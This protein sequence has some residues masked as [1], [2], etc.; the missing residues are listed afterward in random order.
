MP[1]DA[2]NITKEVVIEAFPTISK[3]WK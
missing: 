2:S 1:G 3:H